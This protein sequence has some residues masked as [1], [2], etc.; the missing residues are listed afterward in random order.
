MYI[1]TYKQKINKNFQNKKIINS[2]SSSEKKDHIAEIN[3][4]IYVLCMI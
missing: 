4:Q 1:C 3:L 2:Q